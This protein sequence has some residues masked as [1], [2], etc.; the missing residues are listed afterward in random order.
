[1]KNKYHLSLALLLGLS[2]SW[3]VASVFIDFFAAPAI[4]STITSRDEA[5]SLG[6]KVFTLFNYVELLVAV[7]I[8]SIVLMMTSVKKVRNMLASLILLIF[9]ILYTFILSPNLDKLNNEKANLMEDDIKMEL[10]QSS[11]DFYH[12][13]YVRADSVKILGLLA[14]VIVQIKDINKEDNI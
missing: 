6:V 3:L 4:F 13:F 10:V 12:N 8:L 9:P 1:M 11:L 7:A 5:A 2:L 14:F